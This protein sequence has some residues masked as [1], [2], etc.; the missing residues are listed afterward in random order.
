MSSGPSPQSVDE[1]DARPAETLDGAVTVWN[2]VAEELR[3]YPAPDD[4]KAGADRLYPAERRTDEATILHQIA[5][6]HRPDRYERISRDGTT[7]RVSMRAAPIFDS[8]GATAGGAR[9]DATGR[10]G[11]E[12]RTSLNAI[13]GFT[14]TLAMRRPGPLGGE[15]D[16]QLR[17][18]LSAPRSSCRVSTECHVHGTVDL[19]ASRKC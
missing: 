15:H 6:G 8:T 11:R 9:I 18:V 16:H 7:I 17:L 4:R 2:R 12:L 13:V 3:G 5:D 10:V 1:N 14:G 19:H